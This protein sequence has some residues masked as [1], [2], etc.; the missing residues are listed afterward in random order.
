MFRPL[1][2]KEKQM[3]PNAALELLKQGEYGVLSTAGADGYAYGVPTSYVYWENA[4]Y[5]HGAKVGHK[6]ENIQINNK[7][8]FCVVGKTEVLPAEFNTHYESV[9][10]FGEVT[11]VSDGEKRDALL[12]LAEKYSRGYVERGLEYIE[13]DGDKTSVLKLSIKHISGKAGK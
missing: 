6:H 4:L 1:R 2:R 7:A 11:T 13:K 5:F 10:V 3:D 12:A 8:S 9:S